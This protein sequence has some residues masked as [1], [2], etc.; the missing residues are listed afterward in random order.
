[1][2]FFKG[3]CI[4]G[5]GFRVEGLG[6]RGPVSSLAL[7]SPCWGGLEALGSQSSPSLGVLKIL[8]LGL[9]KFRVEV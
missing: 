8:G 3:Y 7:R 2:G 5:L 9:L 1:M 4:L 6:F